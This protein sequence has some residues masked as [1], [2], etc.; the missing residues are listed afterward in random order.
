MSHCAPGS[1]G[2]SVS[3]FSRPTLVKMAR[4]LNQTAKNENAKRIPVSGNK[5]V[6]WS[7]IRKRLANRCSS[8]V[9]WVDQKFAKSLNDPELN[10]ETFRP[11]MPSEWKR[12]PRTWLTTTDIDE[13]M[14]QYE[15]QYPDFLFFGPV[16]SDCPNGFSCELSNFDPVRLMKGGKRRVGIVY[17]LDKHYEP[18]SHW[19]A[20]FMD[21]G[22]HKDISYYDS[23]GQP[24]PENIKA[25]LKSTQAKLKKSGTKMKLHY[26]RRRHQ[27]GG[28]EC[29]V[30]SMHY[31][32]QRLK[33]KNMRQAVEKKIPD[34]IMEQMRKYLYRPGG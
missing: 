31:L 21:M 32:I 22:K 26:N 18:G 8:E 5:K 19:V 15:R 34:R 9:C 12:N 24:P 1:K 25:F 2:D 16:P 20:V 7:G 29:G 17:N 33:G 23:Y 13:V 3:C 28:S 4:A 14:K 27:Y 11:K 6:I 10:I 30:Y